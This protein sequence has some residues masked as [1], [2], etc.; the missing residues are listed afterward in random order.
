MLSF[1]NALIGNPEALILKELKVTEY[2]L[3]ELVEVS[4]IIAKLPSCREWSRPIP[5]DFLIFA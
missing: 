5:Y 2:P 4:N 1:P 3:T